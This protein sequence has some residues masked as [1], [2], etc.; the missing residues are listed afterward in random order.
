MPLFK[1]SKDAVL[2]AKALT[3]NAYA[4]LAANSRS[5]ESEIEGLLST[6]NDQPCTKKYQEMLAEVLSLMNQLSASF[7]DVEHYCDEVANWIDM[8]LED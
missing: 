2:K 5:M 7:Q 3:E 1:M 4:D 6:L 8:Y